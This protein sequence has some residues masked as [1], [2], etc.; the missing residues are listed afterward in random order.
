MMKQS[1]MTRVTCKEGFILFLFPRRTY[2]LEIYYY[3]L[4]EV[5]LTHV[6]NYVS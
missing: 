1:F 5:I 4:S 2:V 3:Y 6:Q